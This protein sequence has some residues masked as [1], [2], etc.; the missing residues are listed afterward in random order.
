MNIH[1]IKTLVA[2]AL[3]LAASL[4]LTHANL[5]LRLSSDNGA[6]WTTILDGGPDDQST[7]AGVISYQGSV[8][9]WAV[10]LNLGTSKPMQ[11]SAIE[12]NILLSG[13][14][15][16]IGAG[17]LI[18]QLSDTDFTSASVG[19][20]FTS[21]AGGTI[22]QAGGVGGYTTYIDKSNVMFGTPGNSATAVALTTQG[23]FSTGGFSNNKTAL[24]SESGGSPFSVTLEMTLTHFG[25]NYSSFGHQLSAPPLMA[26]NCASGTGQVGVPY[27]SSLVVTGGV[28]PYMFSISSG[29]LPPGLTLDS[30]SGAI[31][32]TPTSAG[33][34]PFT[35][36]VIDSIDSTTGDHVA[37][38]N[39]TIVITPPALQLACA[40]GSGQVG[41]AYSS[42][43]VAG[44][45]TPAYTFSITAGALPPGMTLNPATGAITGTPTSA[46]TFNYA[47][48][49]VDSGSGTAK[50]LTVNCNI[51]IAPPP[52][53]LACAGGSG[54]V[55][56]AYSS[57]LV[58]SGGT[59]PYTFSI[60]VGSLPPGLTLNPL[61]GAISGTPTT[62]GT[63]NYTAKVVDSTGGTA[64]NQ[65]VS[66][67]ITIQPPPET[68]GHGDSATIG[69]WHNKNGQALI[70]SLNGGPNAMNLANWLASNFPYLYGANAGAN[71]LTGKKNSEV[72]AYF[73]TLFNVTGQKTDAQIL[74]GALASYVTSSGLAGNAAASYGFNV[75]V[76]G[77]GAKTYNVGAY[78][79]AIGLQ[80]NTLYTVLQLLQQA[81]LQ[82]KNGTFNANA[83]NVIFDGINQRGDII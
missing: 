75:S 6:T 42:A 56:V 77:T 16:S 17:T 14:D 22:G 27:S 44:G 55:G 39:C 62:A 66:C 60:I 71:K 53:R 83:F 48:K 67:S 63:F 43:L 64:Q 26:L 33:T 29:S 51:M 45:G 31:T 46:G 41:V 72:A 54:K 59:A 82:K 4:T 36:M 28:P 40:G 1:R 80:N 24:S 21:S 9:G 68:L 8:P 69:F 78:G 32:G 11:G 12:P 81:N 58:A 57:A 30:A 3:L 10:T 76:G 2:A 50:T 18:I 61:T 25:A 15:S 38:V 37:F 5:A 47:A 70:N 49:V 7:N 74:A 65:S 23:P 20:T 52:L 73:L 35:A 34:F 13:F 79:T 19:R